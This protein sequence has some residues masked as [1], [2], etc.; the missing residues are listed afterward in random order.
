MIEL[1]TTF[2]WYLV[3]F[4]V[5]MGLLTFFLYRPITEMLDKREQKINN[6][7]D[8]AEKHRQE[9]KELK[10]KYQAKL[11]KAR[12]EA[13]QIVQKAEKRG[14]KKAREIIAEAEEDAEKF[15]QR[16]LEEIEQA[17]RDAVREVRDYATQLSLQTAGKFIQAEMDSSQH[18]QL[19][20]QYIEELD[21]EKLGEVQ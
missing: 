3:N 7:L 6:D 2:I 14:K 4:L 9:A 18:Q 19:I 11:Q 10:E 8:Q 16:K 20:Q 13:Q 17:K 1:N 21:A 15:K 12:Q 5:L